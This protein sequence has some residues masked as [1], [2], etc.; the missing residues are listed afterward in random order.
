MIILRFSFALNSW[1]KL[2]IPPAE[3]SQILHLPLKYPDVAA[4]C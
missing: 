4:Y 1:E 3:V 2:M